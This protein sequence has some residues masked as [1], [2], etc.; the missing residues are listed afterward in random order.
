[1]DD[2]IQFSDEILGVTEINKYKN[3]DIQQFLGV[4][5]LTLKEETKRNLIDLIA[6]RKSTELANYM[7]K[8]TTEDLSEE[9]IIEVI[10]FINAGYEKTKT[11]LNNL[12]QTFN[13]SLESVGIL[14]PQEIAAFVG[15]VNGYQASLQGSYAGFLAFGNQAKSFLRTYKNAQIS[16]EQSLALQ[17]KEREIQ[18][19]S[20]ASG[21]LSASVGL[22]KTL[23]GTQNT[24]ADLEDQITLLK[25]T[26]D[27]TKKNYEVTL[28]SL[29]NAIREAQIGYA[30]AQKEFAKL[31]ITSPINGT[32]SQVFVDK[33]QEIAPSVKIA[34]II[35]D[36]TPEIQIAFSSKEKDL[37][38]LGQKVY[39]DVGVERI[40]GTIYSLSD[41]ADANLNYIA[42]VVFESGTNIL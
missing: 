37:V 27:N 21:E 31:T 13:S 33:G 36:R 25:N 10:D 16:I 42:T 28:R 39:V 19:K 12:E 8:I 34:D 29:D 17:K 11:L 26:L 32:V 1:M 30:S 4:K 35:S 14:G 18:L 9:E 3:E 5:D 15:E 6:L 38:Q 24:I 7:N 23:L 22:E 41:V 40:S 20:L 2:I